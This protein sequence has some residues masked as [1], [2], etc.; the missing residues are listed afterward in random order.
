MPTRLLT[1]ISIISVII[2]VLCFIFFVFLI[3]HVNK[4]PY[5]EASTVG[6]ILLLFL[7]ELNL[8]FVVLII[9]FETDELKETFLMISNT[10]I[11]YAVIIILSTR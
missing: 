10:F 9:H 5:R 1:T 4:F 6:N 8:V 7:M 2:F 11:H 3:L